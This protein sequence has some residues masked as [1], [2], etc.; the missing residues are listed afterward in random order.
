LRKQSRGSNVP[1]LLIS[2]YGSGITE[3][4]LE[5]GADEAAHKLLDFNFLIEQ[6]EQ[7][8]AA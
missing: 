8:L 2:A 7:F 3:N 4:A 5:A 1:V 6:V